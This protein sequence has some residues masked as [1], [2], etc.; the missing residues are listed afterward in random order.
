MDLEGAKVRTSAVADHR[1]S[2]ENPGSLEENTDL[3]GKSGPPHDHENPYFVDDWDVSVLSSPGTGQWMIVR[4]IGEL[5]SPV[6]R[7]RKLR[8]RQ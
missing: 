3:V 1:E 7:D 6:E 4:T 8:R 5:S 2:V